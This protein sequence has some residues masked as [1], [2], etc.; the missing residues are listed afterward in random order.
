MTYQDL[1]TLNALLNAISTVLLIK[2]YFHIRRKEINQHYQMMS[3]AMVSSALFLASYLTYHTLRQMSE[4]VGHT[5]FPVEGWLK[6]L[7]YSILIPHIILAAV[8]LPLILITFYRGWKSQKA[9]STPYVNR[10]R[11]IARYTF[12]I[13][14]FV[15]VTGVVVY[16]LLYQIAPLLK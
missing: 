13:W 9:H 6:T 2:G 7:Y 11:K 4:G 12:P 14:L 3:A 5:V 15:S 10:H 1:P 16:L 8:V